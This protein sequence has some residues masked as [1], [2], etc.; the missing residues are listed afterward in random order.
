[1]LPAF[2]RLLRHSTRISSSP[3]APRTPVLLYSCRKDVGT[4]ILLF[5]HPA[6]HI[7]CTMAEIVPSDRKRIKDHRLGRS[8]RQVWRVQ[9][10]E[11]CLQKLYI[12]RARGRI[13]AREGQISSLCIICMSMGYVSL[14][15]SNGSWKSFADLAIASPSHPNREEAQR[16]GGYHTLHQRPLAHA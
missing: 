2:H 3:G 1:M 12:S 7:G 4:H 11:V 10:R 13:S 6:G 9:K 16:L 8:Q 15:F 5:S 14:L